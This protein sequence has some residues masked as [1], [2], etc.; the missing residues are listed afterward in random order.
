MPIPVILAGLGIALGASG[1]AE[2]K[3]TNEKAQ[4][5]AQK[6][7]ELYD[8]SKERLEKEKNKTQLALMKLGY[9]KKHT[10]DT[11]LK[12]FMQYYPKIK[13]VRWTESTGLDELADFN[14][15]MQDIMQ[16]RELENIYSEVFETSA[17]GAVT[18]AAIT[19]AAGSAL[20]AATL[21]A[22]V[23]PLSMI[24]APAVLFSAISASLKADENLEKATQMYAES[25][26]ASEEM[27]NSRTICA[28]VT[29]RSEMFNDLLTE[30]NGMFSQCSDQLAGIV[31]SKEGFIFKKKLNS[32]DFTNEEIKL[33]AITAAL[34][35]A[36]KSVIDTPILST[37]GSTVSYESKEAYETLEDSVP[38]LTSRAEAAINAEYRAAPVLSESKMEELGL[39]GLIPWGGIR[40]IGAFV[41]GVIAALILSNIIVRFIPTAGQ[42]FLFLK[43][44]TVDKFALWLIIC[45]MVTM[46]FGEC[47]ETKMEIACKIGTGVGMLLMYIQYCQTVGNMKHYIIVSVIVCILFD[48]MYAALNKKK[49]LW[50]FADFFCYVLMYAASYPIL[51]LLCALL[52][53]VIRIPSIICLTA[54]TLIMAFMIFGSLVQYIDL[55]E[56]GQ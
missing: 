52:N 27:E 42:K 33:I 32:E 40:G 24:A 56:L 22:A 16:L 38:L 10:L 4:K 11:S 48:V 20:T 30:L 3:E 15:D 26:A 44:S 29:K 49:A 37:D 55:E 51:F 17:V 1:H 39:E 23:T 13:D 19:V 28:A 34:A 50:E 35:K 31:K 53:K 2:A 9:A 21:S 6:A 45:G 8:T 46:F 47:R 43:A 7:Q 41:A 25:E 18:G 14:I 36:V 12:Q 5:L 54:T